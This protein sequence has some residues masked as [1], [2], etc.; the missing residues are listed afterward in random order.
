MVLISGYRE[1]DYVR[2]A[3]K[4]GVKNY[5]VK[6]TNYNE[7]VEVFTSIKNELDEEKVAISIFEASSADR[8]NY[9]EQD[10]II[11]T[12]KDYV[13]EHYSDATLEDAAKIVYMNPYYLSNFFKQ[14]SG[15]K[16]SDFLTEIKMKKAAELLKDLSNKTY[17]VGL[18]VGYK[19]PKNFT[20]AFKKYYGKSPSEFKNSNKQHTN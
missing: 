4:Y 12:I 3:L 16:F 7:V 10:E 19:N 11:K 13:I 15:Q 17:E 1:F 18:K 9:N 20:R 8:N 6:P 2:T 5:I 14:K